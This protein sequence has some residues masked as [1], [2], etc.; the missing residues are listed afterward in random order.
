LA[1]AIHPENYLDR[2]GGSPRPLYPLIFNLNGVAAWRGSA[3]ANFFFF[4]FNTTLVSPALPFPTPSGKRVVHVWMGTVRHS[5]GKGLDPAVTD[6]PGGSFILGHPD[7]H[8]KL[9]RF[10]RSAAGAWARTRA[11]VVGGIGDFRTMPLTG[12]AGSVCRHQTC[13]PR[14]VV[15]NPLGHTS[16]TSSSRDIKP[17]VCSWFFFVT[18]EQSV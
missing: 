5:S 2:L 11:G 13:P 8:L 4:C 15:T 7:P 1:C 12:V 14:V 17:P 16:T 18:P 9:G 6:I 10:L 3:P